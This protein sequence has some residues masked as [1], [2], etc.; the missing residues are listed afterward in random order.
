[1]VFAGFA[2]STFSIAASIAFG[3][4]V[5]VVADVFIVRL[6]LMPAVLSLLGRGA[7]WLPHWLDKALPRLDTE[8]H[9]LTEEPARV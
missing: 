1:M 7:R 5:G 9:A 2:L 8:G 6:V 4:M 3:L